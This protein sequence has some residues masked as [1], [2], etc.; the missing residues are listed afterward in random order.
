MISP[1]P[2][3]NVSKAKMSENSTNDGQSQTTRLFALGNPISISIIT[4]NQQ[5]VNQNF[6]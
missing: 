3:D 6:S 1:D 5:K 2:Y 4:K